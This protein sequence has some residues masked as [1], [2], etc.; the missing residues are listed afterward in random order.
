VSDKIDQRLMIVVNAFKQAIE[1]GVSPGL[2]VN[3][4]PNAFFLFVNGEID[5]KRAAE[6]AL[7]RVDAYDESVR[8]AQEV[9]D[10]AARK[11]ASVA[12]DPG[13]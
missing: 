6:T 2:S 3:R 4:H 7:Q 8:L 10:A 5:L 1:S 9:A 11:A 12:N 13:A